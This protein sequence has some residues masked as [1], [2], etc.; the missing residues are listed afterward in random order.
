MDKVLRMA[1]VAKMR[2]HLIADTGSVGTDDNNVVLIPPGKE[3]ETD[4]KDIA[5]YTLPPGTDIQ[6]VLTNDEFSYDMFNASIDDLGEDLLVQCSDDIGTESLSDS[7]DHVAHRVK[8]MLDTLDVMSDTTYQVVVKEVGELAHPQINSGVVLEISLISVAIATMIP[9]INGAI[10]LI[11][12]PKIVDGKV[13]TTY[14]RKTLSGLIEKMSWPYGKLS[15]EATS[16]NGLGRVS[17]GGR[18]VKSALRSAS[19]YKVIGK[20]VPK[21]A[22]L[23][24]LHSLKLS[25]AQLR[26]ALGEF[27]KACI[28]AMSS[29][30]SGIPMSARWMLVG[31][32]I[33]VIISLVTYVAIGGMRIVKH[34]V[35]SEK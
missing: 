16:K 18:K 3:H 1:S 17:L 32:I 14:T 11:Q 22:M 8:K 4:V 28:T 9:V 26:A 20:P 13:D 23:Q 15:V 29:S 33:G 34:R 31:G 24:A 6:P 35:H 25:L 21:Q 30:L 27:A 7:V 5:P 19:G 12:K 2:T 10:Y